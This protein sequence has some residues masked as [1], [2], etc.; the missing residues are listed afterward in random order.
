M[1]SFYL[2]W[3]KKSFLLTTG[4]SVSFHKAFWPLAAKKLF[5]SHAR[6]LW[7]QQCTT[8][9]VRNTENR[10]SHLFSECQ[11]GNN[12]VWLMSMFLT[13]CEKQLWAE[14][15]PAVSRE[16]TAIQKWTKVPTTISNILCIIGRFFPPLKIHRKD[17][18]FN[19]Y[20]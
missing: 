20:Y 3:G 12:F 14:M 17:A 16:P 2:D 7:L 11:V 4:V 6:P 9:T 13:A 8:V 19:A 15:A 1:V 5:S 10:E 18:Y